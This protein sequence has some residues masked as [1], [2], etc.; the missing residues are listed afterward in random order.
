MD[1]MELV[2]YQD[3]AKPDKV[4]SILAFIRNQI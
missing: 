3:Y 2:T 4:G 1:W